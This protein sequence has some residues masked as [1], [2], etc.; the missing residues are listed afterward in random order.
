MKITGTMVNYYVHC[1]RQCYLFSNN[2]NLEDNSEDV[3]IGR[4]LHKI[5]SEDKKN[6]EVKLENISIDKITDKYIVEIKKSDADVEATKMQVLYY[7][8]VL[9]QKGI[10]KIGQ[11]KCIEKNKNE[12]VDEIIL[13]DENREKIQ[14]CIKEIEILVTSNKVPDISRTRGCKKCAYYEYCYI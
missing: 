2:V 11:I 12:S 10:T 8:Y 5:K 14:N 6:Y 1:K 7:L 9:E 13:T 3:R 4:I